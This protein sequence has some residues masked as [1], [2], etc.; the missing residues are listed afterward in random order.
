M[1]TD[2]NKYFEATK[3]AGLS[4]DI[5]A[6]KL[7]TAKK[8]LSLALRKFRAYGKK[9]LREAEKALILTRSDGPFVESYFIKG[10]DIEVSVERSSGEIMLYSSNREH[11][12]C[13]SILEIKT[14]TTY[15][16]VSVWDEALTAD[17]KEA[18]NHLIEF[19]SA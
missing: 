15:R 4:V 19:I 6:S 12:F 8:E 10:I 9:N 5:A 7:K 13:L 18:I 1:L 3:A 16:N 14:G 2:Y 11:Y 17:E